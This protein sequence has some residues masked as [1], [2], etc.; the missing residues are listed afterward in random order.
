MCLD[1]ISRHASSDSWTC[2]ALPEIDPPDPFLEH[3]ARPC[4][5]PEATTRKMAC[6]S[7]TIKRT[8]REVLDGDRR[9]PK[10][11]SLI[12]PDCFIFR[13]LRRE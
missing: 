9:L 12:S 13:S 3:R 4:L 11:L 1:M 6:L 7:G 2:M 8:L 10:T 5:T